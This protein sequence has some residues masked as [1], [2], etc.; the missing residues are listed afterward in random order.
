[1]KRVLRSRACLC[2]S[3]AQARADLYEEFAQTEDFFDHV[4]E[5]DTFESLYAELVPKVTD[6]LLT[7][8]SNA[9]NDD[10]RRFN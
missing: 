10:Q 8:R 4:I 6:G 7:R 2:S 9:W 3:N 5:G 1:M